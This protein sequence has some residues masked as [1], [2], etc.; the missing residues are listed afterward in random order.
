MTYEGGRRVALEM[1]CLLMGPGLLLCTLNVLEK[2]RGGREDDQT[3][4]ENSAWRRRRTRG[5]G[6]SSTDASAEATTE[7]KKFP[8]LPPSFHCALLD[9]VFLSLQLP[10]RCVRSFV[11]SLARSLVPS[12]LASTWGLRKISG[13]GFEFKGALFN[14]SEPISVQEVCIL[15]TSN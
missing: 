15:Y 7:P 3:A 6:G 10:R 1:K 8:P 2:N 9:P 11:R 14:Y 12:F 4:D 13:R 5:G